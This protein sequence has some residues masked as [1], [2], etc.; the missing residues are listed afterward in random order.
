M[1]ESRHIFLSYRSSEVDFALRLAADLK[2]AGVNLWMDRLDINP[3]DD[4]RKSLQAAVYNS[5]AMISV[6]SPA[7]VNSE[8]CQREL[9][10][11]DRLKRPIFPVLLG[12]IPESDWP[13]EIER[14]QYIDFSHW[15]DDNLIYQQ[16]VSAL[17]DILKE[18]F[19]G[20]ISVIP[21][22][23]TQYLTSLIAELETRYSLNYYLESTTTADKWLN[24]E[25][26]R[27]QPHN[28]RFW[29]GQKMF[30]LLNVSLTDEQ[31][32]SPFEPPFQ[33]RII[34]TD[35]YDVL[36]NHRQ[37]VLTGA[38]D[39]GKTTLLRHLVLDAI[40]AYQATTDAPIPLLLDLVGWDDQ[41]NLDEFIRASWPLTSDPIKLV[42]Q[43]RL[44]LYMD[45]LNE[46][47]GERA[48]KVQELGT[49]LAAN[50]ESRQVIITC[51]D[52][53]FGRDVDLGLPVIQLGT[54]D[55][56][57]IESFVIN[58][59]G[60]EIAPI[61][62]SELLPQSNWED[63]H[64]RY[65]YALAKNPVLLS[66]LIIVYK[67]SPSGDTPPNLGVLLKRV[68]REIWDRKNQD[69]TIESIIYEEL[70]AALA[71]LAYSM[72]QD[73]MG[74]HTPV[75]Y[76]LEIMGDERQLY[77]A[78]SLNLIEL[79]YGNVRFVYDIFR[80]YYAALALAKHDITRNVFPPQLGRGGVYQPHKWDR[81]VIILS[82]L[83]PEHQVN[84]VEIARQNPF[85]ALECIAS[86]LNVSDRLIEP[87]MGR[88]I[89]IAN[90]KESDAR[91]ATARILGK[92]NYD[93]ALP[94]LL[95]AM[96]DGQWD[97]RWAAMLSLREIEV[98][99]LP[100]L[101]EVLEELDHST[102]ESAHMAIRYL[103]ESALPTLLELLQHQDRKT[104]RSAA[105][106][107]GYIKDL[108]A[109]PALVQA[110]YDEDNLV[111]TEAAR[112]LATI[113]DPAAIPW[114]LEILH[115]PNTRVRKAAA[116]ALCDMGQIAIPA[117]LNALEDK[118]PDIRRLIIAV[119][120]EQDDPAILPALLEAS[121]DR[122]V[123]VRGAAIA[124][125]E[126]R[127][128]RAVV[129]RLM[130]CLGDTAI[131]TGNRKRICDIAARILTNI[132][133]SQPFETVDQA[134]DVHLASDYSS[135]SDEAMSSKS[136]GSAAEAKIRLLNTKSVTSDTDHTDLPLAQAMND[137]DW[138]VRLKAIESIDPDDIS[139]VSTLLLIQA[140]DDV[141]TQVRITALKAIDTDNA[142]ACVNAWQKCLRDTDST[143][144]ESCIDYILSRGEQATSPLIELTKSSN[145]LVKA[146]SVRLLGLLGD[147]RAVPAIIACLSDQK[148]AE[149]L[150]KRVCD[151]AATSLRQLGTPQALAALK[152]WQP[153]EPEPAG[154]I[155]TAAPVAK[156]GHRLLLGQILARLRQ[157]DWGE[158]EEAAKALREYARTLHGNQ[159]PTTIKQLEAALTDP[160]WIVRWAATEALAWIGDQSAVPQLLRIIDDNNWTVRVAVVRALLEIGDPNAAQYISPLLKDKNCTVR[161][162]AAEALGFLGNPASIVVLT[163]SLS[164]D[165]ALV[166][167][168]A[169]VALGKINDPAVLEPLTAALNDDDSH[170][171]WASADALREMNSQSI[172][173][174]LIERL[175]DV[176]KPYWEDKR[177]CDLAAEA[178]IRIGTADA[179][180]AVEDWQNQQPVSDVTNAN[181][182][183]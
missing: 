80:D 94:I 172:V 81:P 52:E 66:A 25:L 95:E 64:K 167:L 140:I 156:D 62:L 10:R 183:E 166:R 20:Q 107:L 15:H 34:V 27:P 79:R 178:L 50:R 42:K 92:I 68:V 90:T 116:K 44:A 131:T 165:E 39:S 31:R 49:W 112:A 120:G 179:R 113:R 161:E 43:G 143:F 41:K 130:E 4:W 33:K 137:P 177:I 163:E 12:V 55:R 128:D 60:E 180:M 65:L 147:V 67:S 54:L 132:T 106:A 74:I 158:K 126:G 91:V 139:P 104:R 69:G 70:E 51:R 37:I 18:R 170:V 89:Q 154:V 97:V 173:P 118:R 35:L 101:T 108:A 1:S 135:E 148:T 125:L 123:D 88:L 16:R 142:G 22:P 24:R 14:Q 103:G 93:L 164:D 6:L 59:L 32:A 75:E 9:A 181:S 114:L 23:E 115:H 111:S 98:A 84:L 176:E 157:S 102:Q 122:N 29:L 169:V 124:A 152:S 162:A 36:A 77:A 57:N 78:I 155:Q 168:A 96:R 129:Q 117:L 38:S 19:A 56:H 85:L 105:W 110:L 159:D 153:T 119:L 82:G 61:L 171:R 13:L 63:D 11:A 83:L 21:D 133:P 40:Y 47:W 2:N 136:Q 7:Y 86:G 71:D 145:T 53:A 99:T 127:E 141:E 160:A 8:Y 87:I 174:K 134:Q 100:G 5:A 26:I 46:I 149:T 58:Y 72:I 121:F 150:E 76:A 48:R 45:G 144:A 3:G 17:V 175:Q 138:Q 109:V 73:E 146:R 182:P 30:A 28:V 151:F